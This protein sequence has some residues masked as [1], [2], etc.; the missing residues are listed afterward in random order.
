MAVLLSLTVCGVFAQNIVGDWS[1]VLQVQSMKLHVVF[2]ITK[3][4]GT[5]SATMDSPD[6]GAKGIP[7]TSTGFASGQLTLKLTSAGI[8]YTAMVDNSDSIVGTFTQM[9][10][11]FP[12]VLKRQTVAQVAQKRSQEPTPHY[13]YKSEDVTFYNVHDSV[14]LAGTLT[15]PS[16]G[17]N[18]TAVVLVTGSGAQNRDEELLGHKPFLVLAD[19]LTR[20]GIAVLRYDDRGSFQ[21]TGDFASATTFDFARDAEAAVKYLRTRKEINPKKIGVM[22]HSEGG[23]IAPMVAVNDP[24][25]NFIVMLAGPGIPGDS[26]L[27]LQAEAI[28]RANG[29]SDSLLTMN[30]NLSRKIYKMIESSLPSDTLQQQL[31]EML[32]PIV[33][34]EMKEVSTEQQNAYIQQQINVMLSP[35]M[36][37]FMSYNPAPTL[38][39]VK[40]AVLALNGSKDLQVPPAENLPAIKHALKVGGNKHYTIKELPGLNHLFQECKTGSPN[41]YA[42]IEETFSPEALRVIANWILAR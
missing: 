17:S 5:Y 12:L 16:S 10:Q 25:V 29:I 24:K 30:R 13:P 2:H 39:K 38:E 28:G 19:Y 6:Q 11:A 32:K 37:T 18:F 34:N 14:T 21:S 26:I 9:G 8:V 3:S 35:W 20:H 41:E 42:E 15:M 33:E 22:G 4:D 7:M 27:L 23:L 40:C 31:T 36:R 1:G